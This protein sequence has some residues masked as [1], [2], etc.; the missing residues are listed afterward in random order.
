M[1]KH[2]GA[3]DP[4]R[5]IYELKSYCR[6]CWEPVRVMHSRYLFETS[7]NGIKT[8]VH[9]ACGD[10]KHDGCI[11]ASC[12]VCRGLIINPDFKG[13]LSYLKGFCTTRDVCKHICGYCGK[14]VDRDS[15]DVTFIRHKE[16]TCVHKE[17][18][19]RVLQ[20]CD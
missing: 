17:C 4:G 18:F 8:Y 1:A 10:H 12:L 2:L 9:Q 7:P 3:N 11:A 14:P 5:G 6:I 20:K 13:D 15:D 19:R 16:G